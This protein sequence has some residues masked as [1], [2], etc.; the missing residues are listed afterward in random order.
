MSHREKKNTSL[1]KEIEDNRKYPFQQCQDENINKDFR[2]LHHDIVN[3][4]IQFCLKHNIIIDE[5]GLTA[6]EVGGS[7]KS[8]SWQACTDS[9]FT[10]DKF[11]QEHKK[12]EPFLISL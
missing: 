4:V 6:D 12:E 9:C 7:I 5:F 2:I 3:M 8:G 1:W 10:F 11:S